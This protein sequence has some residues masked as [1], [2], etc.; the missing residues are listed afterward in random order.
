MMKKASHLECLELVMPSDYF[1]FN[2]SSPRI[3]VVSYFYVVRLDVP[4]FYRIIWEIPER[5]I[6]NL[7]DLK[8]HSMT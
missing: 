2:L 7:E 1:K 8:E 3:L 6:Q 4:W 5:G